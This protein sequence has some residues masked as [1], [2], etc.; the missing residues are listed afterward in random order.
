MSRSSIAQLDAEILAKVHQLIREDRASIDEILSAISALGGDAS[1]SAVGRYVKNTRDQMEHFRQAQEM[2]KV[3]VG[4]L[5]NNPN[6]DVGLLLSQMLRTVAWQTLATQGAGNEPIDVKDIGH[7]AKAIKDL[8]GADKLAAD[9]EL[10]IR[11][12]FATQAA[13]AAADEAQE[14]GLSR[15][16]VDAIRSRILGVAA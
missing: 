9:R 3:W 5:E 12:E 14:Q 2:S 8:A 6:S 15:A 4:Q 11:K 16:T 1:R 13:D 7:L 10:R